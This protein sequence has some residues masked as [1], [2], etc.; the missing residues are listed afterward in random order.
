[1]FSILSEQ[2][3]GDLLEPLAFC[4]VD[5]Q[6]RDASNVLLQST[7]IFIGD[8]RDK[9]GDTF[10]DQIYPPADTPTFTATT[11]PAPLT[12]TKLELVIVFVQIDDALGSVYFDQAAL[13]DLGP[14]N[15]DDPWNLSFEHGLVGS[16]PP[17]WFTT[18]TNASQ[19]GDAPTNGERALL[20]F[21][22]FPGDGS[23]NDTITRSTT[24][25]VVA[26]DQVDVSA[27]AQHLAGDPIAVDN[28]AF[29]NVEYYDGIGALVGFDGSD[30]LLPTDPTDTPKQTTVLSTAPAGAVSAAVALGYQQTNEGAGAV[31]WDDVSFS[32]TTPSGCDG[33]ANGDL[34][35]DVNDISF[36][37]FRLGQTNGTCGDG[38]ANGD[39]A[40]NVNDISY[41][42]FR[43]GTCNP[44]GPC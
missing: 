6:F 9:D 5:V 25:D 15:F 3:S 19:N 36:V 29:L 27:W 7:V 4:L 12:A 26:G 1:M 16:T 20:Q 23:L 42:L 35:V 18:G 34:A 43:L 11:P 41:V 44:G 28:L 8:N 14:F 31:H 10:P 24:F 17:G 22:N 37:L 33:D 30:A 38:D 21:G 40:N 39:G 32:V 2:R 13:V